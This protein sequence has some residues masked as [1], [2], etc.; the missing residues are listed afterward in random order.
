LLGFFLKIYT[1]YINLLLGYDPGHGPG[2]PGPISAPEHPYPEVSALIILAG[3][4]VMVEEA[5]GGCCEMDVVYCYN[6]SYENTVVQTNR[7]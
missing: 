1:T 3:D 4:D 7:I 6:D 2:G 5:G